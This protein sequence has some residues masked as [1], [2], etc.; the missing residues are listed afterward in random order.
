MGGIMRMKKR[1]LMILSL[2]VLIAGLAGTGYS[3]DNKIVLKYNELDPAT[4]LMTYSAQYFANLVKTETKGRITIDIYPSGQLAGDD[5]RAIQGVQMGAVDMYRANTNSMGDFGLQKVNV[6]AL[7]FMFRDRA[8]IWKVMNGPIGKEVFQEIL[9]KKVHFI[10]LGYMEEGARDFF[11][12]KKKVS[13]VSDMA[14]LKIR[15]PGNKMMM[16]TTKAFG[17]SPTPIS[18]SELYSALQTGVI[19]GAEQPPAGYISNKY[20]E[21][22]KYYTLDH[23]TYSPSIVIISE[24]RWKQLSPKDQK[25]ILDCMKKAEPYN[26]K[27]A[28][29]Q[30]MDALKQMK[31]A[32][33]VVTDV[34]DRAA[35]QN[36]VKPIY[37]EYGASIKDLIQRVRDTK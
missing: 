29:Q 4:H 31:A 22:S 17:A 37:E 10:P 12:S 32:G 20:N 21:V 11:F 27:L 30:D 36:A 2:C 16:D 15:V 34:T 18:F 13:K 33:A 6:F 35:W 7:P 5:T 28:E 19:D 25:I 26:R 24:M 3:A 9:D 8:H 14:G 23:H 1:V